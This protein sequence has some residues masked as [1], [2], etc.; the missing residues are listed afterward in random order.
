MSS[1]SSF[2]PPRPSQ[3]RTAHARRAAPCEDA[4][5]S[6]G[7]SPT[8]HVI[9]AGAVARAFVRRLS[10]LPLRVTAWSDSRAT[11]F[12][13][14]GLPLEHLLRRLGRGERLADHP[15]ARVVS[16]EL[17]HRLT[18]FDAVVDVSATR[19]HDAEQEFEF[20]QRSRKE[21]TAWVFASKH[22]PQHDPQALFEQG[23][24]IG[25]VG[26][27][28]VLGGTGRAL[29][30]DLPRLRDECEE[31]TLVANATSSVV[32]D[33]LAA[34]DS[35]D[36]AVAEA[37]QR[38]LL[39]ADPALDLDGIDAAGKLALAAALV[40]EQDARPRNVN[41]VPLSGVDPRGLREWAQQGGVT[42]F[43]ARADRHG[44]RSV[45]PEPLDRWNSLATQHGE[46]AY[47]YT[48]RN[49]DRV[50]HLGR[51]LGPE[52]VADALLEDL[53]A[54]ISVHPEARS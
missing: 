51:G 28:A 45:A 30:A 48:L 50:L 47:R 37:R 14:D 36:G 5:L 27:H 49:G 24:A 39:E 31:I 42:R 3:P 34:G 11:L 13:P 10:S 7:T 2:T 22:V 15:N 43:V 52:G 6:S 46:V 44:Q 20:V 18:R 17:L 38:G 40:F 25:P 54:C 23:D 26:I 33:R 1:T 21:G 35:Y 53:A 32:L 9:G 16:R 19:P 41:R 4:F 12:D 8:L 29:L